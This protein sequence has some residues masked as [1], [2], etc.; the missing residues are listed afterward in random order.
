MKNVKNSIFFMVAGVIWLL[1][2]SVTALSQK[3]FINEFMASNQFTSEDEDGDASDWLELFNPTTQAISL[4]GHYLTDDVDDRLK[5]QF[6]DRMLEPDGFMIIWASD[7]DRTG[8]G[9]LHTNFKISKSGEYLGL[10]D[11][12]GNVVDS[13]SFGEQKQDISYGRKQDG[14][15]EWTF[16]S[17]PTPGE[18]NFSDGILLPSPR[19][20]HDQGYYNGPVTI[21]LHSTDQTFDIYYTTNGDIPT[22]SSMKYES[23]IRIDTTTAIRAICY[24]DNECSSQ[25]V[26]KTFLVDESIELPILSLVTDNSN[27]YDEEKGIFFNDYKH[28]SEWERPAHVSY[29][30]IENGLEFDMNAGIRVHGTA[31][32]SSRKKSLRLYFRSEYGQSELNYPVFESK[33]LAHFKRLILRMGGQDHNMYTAYWTLIR[34]P[35][36]QRLHS[37]VQPTFATSRPFMMFLNGKLWGIYYFRERVDKYYLEDNFSVQNADLN[38]STWK[39][40]GETIEGDREHWDDTFLFFKSKNLGEP[41]NMAIARQLVDI[42]NFTDHNIFNIFGANWDWPQNNVYKFRDRDTNGPWRWIMWD[43]DA[44]FG[45]SSRAKSPTWNAIEWATRDQVRLDL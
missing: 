22:Q 45:R 36:L 30:K 1:T 14:G 31:T 6:P 27:L 21:S 32:R 33:D 39:W 24:D 42:E 29:F 4:S 44:I 15:M 3:L 43:V 26:T 40:G 16:F 9:Q 7:K 13:L 34:C 37:E 8:A 10:Y 41:E 19:F 23:E 28:G 12:N 25:V 38:K 11:K 2:G 5:W 20:S 18:S 17:Q 35:L